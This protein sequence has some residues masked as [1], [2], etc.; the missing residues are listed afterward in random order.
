[1]RWDGTIQGHHTQLTLR[2]E[3]QVRCPQMSSDF[4]DFVPETN[5]PPLN[6]RADSTLCQVVRGLHSLVLPEGEQVLP[7]REKP[8]SHTGHFSI[9]GEFVHLEAVA[10]T[11]PKRHRFQDKGLPVQTLVP[12]RIATLFPML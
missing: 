9:S 3:N 8:P 1:M 12:Q 10:H 7:V 6:R 5:L 2:R 11:G 4:T